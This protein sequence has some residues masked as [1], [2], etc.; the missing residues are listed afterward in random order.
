[1]AANYLPCEPQ[2]M[3]LLPESPQEWLPE[4]HL[5]HFISDASDASDGVDLGAFHALRQGRSAQAATKQ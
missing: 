5:A 3:M 2:Q 1:M 4:G